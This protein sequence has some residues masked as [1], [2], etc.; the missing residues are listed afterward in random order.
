MSHSG[1]FILIAFTLYQRIGVDIEFIYDVPEINQIAKIILS[2]NEYYVFKFLSQ[3]EKIEVFFHYWTRK[4][5]ITKAIGIGLSQPPNSITTSILPG[6][7]AS[8]IT[9]NG[10]KKI[11]SSWLVQSLDL[12]P[13]YATALA[14]EYNEFE[15]KIYHL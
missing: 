6:K 7:P 1:R 9:L 14:V 11:A 4:E 2:E 8:L 3:E 12:D 10:D 13:N 5:A 15:L